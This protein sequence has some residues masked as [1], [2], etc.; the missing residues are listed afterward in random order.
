[1]SYKKPKFYVFLAATLFGIVV[2][3][4]SMTNQPKAK[5]AVQNEVV[6]ETEVA[7]GTEE[8]AEELTEAAI[9]EENSEEETSNASYA[10]SKEEWESKILEW[11]EEDY[12]GDNIVK[13]INVFGP[14]DG[15]YGPDVLVER[16]D[17]NINPDTNETEID[18]YLIHE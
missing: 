12:R 7:E 18:V 3:G 8:L 15:V 9:S 6:E 17:S 2:F 13:K 4:I 14:E 5:A 16:L 1:M 10:T 11:Y